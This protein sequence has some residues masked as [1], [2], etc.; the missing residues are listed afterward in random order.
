MEA[1]YEKAENAMRRVEKTGVIGD[2]QT[3]MITDTLEMQA[4]DL[5]TPPAKPPRTY[6]EPPTQRAVLK[7]EEVSNSDNDVQNNVDSDVGVD[8]EDIAALNDDLNALNEDLSALIEDNT[9]A[10]EDINAVTDD[11]AKVIGLL[12]PAV[13][14]SQQNHVSDNEDSEKATSWS[15]DPEDLDNYSNLT[16]K[17]EEEKYPDLT[18]SENSEIESDN[19]FTDYENEEMIQFHH[20]GPAKDE[21]EEEDEKQCWVCFANEEDDPAAAFVHPCRCRGTTKWVHQVCIQRWVDEKQKGNN[22]AGVSCPQCGTEYFIKFPDAG[23]IVRILDAFDKLIGRLC[24]VIAGGVG[25]GSLYWTCVTYGAVTVMQI[26]GH[27]RGLCLMET[28]DPLLLLVSLPLVPLG[29]VLGKMVKWQEPLLQG[30]RKYVPRMSITRFLLP[31]FSIQPIREGSSAAASLPASAEP[32]SVTRTFCGAL[33]FPT[34]A[35]FL[36][37]ALFDNIKSPLRR[38]AMGGFT[39][40]A[41]KGVLKIY[42]KQHTYIRQCK[43]L[44]LDFE[45]TERGTQTA[46]LT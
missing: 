5:S 9:A 36:G 3:N 10:V 13:E 37:R 18:S 12:W 30:L 4:P 20:P 26:T 42:H 21:P 24:P 8:V 32:V 28:A 2:S 16:V 39:F 31:V 19:D 43:R 15:P 40:V 41:V 35:T 44:I 7:K 6:D 45:E 38:A 23:G 34:V 17:D 27:E 25:V 46:Q 11:T 22:Y 29:L 1:S 14:S 33:F